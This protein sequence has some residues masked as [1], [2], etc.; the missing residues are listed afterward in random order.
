MKNRVALALRPK[1]KKYSVR[2]VRLSPRFQR[3]VDAE[4]QSAIIVVRPDRDRLILKNSVYEYD[5][6]AG[7]MHTYRRERL[8]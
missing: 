6:R 2:E 4:A 7:K 8:A 1:S 5:Y 3:L